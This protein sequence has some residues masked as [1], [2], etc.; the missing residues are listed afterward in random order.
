M[1]MHACMCVCTFFYP[2]LFTEK[3]KKR[4]KKKNASILKM[5]IKAWFLCF[6]S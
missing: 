3:I 1:C 5:F 4:F 6:F 2:A